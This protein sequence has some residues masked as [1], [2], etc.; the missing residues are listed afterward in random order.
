MKRPFEVSVTGNEEKA[1]MHV[2]KQVVRTC[3]GSATDNLPEGDKR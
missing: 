2:R 3:A 1:E